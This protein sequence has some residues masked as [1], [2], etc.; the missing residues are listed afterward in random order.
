MIGWVI[1]DGLTRQVCLVSIET[2]DPSVSEATNY[3]GPDWE[4]RKEVRTDWDP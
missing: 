3:V 2:F 1:D 4:A